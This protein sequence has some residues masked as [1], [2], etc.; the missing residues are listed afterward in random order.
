MQEVVQELGYPIAAEAKQA[1]IDGVIEALIELTVAK[2]SA[3]P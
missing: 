3:V 1:T 2:V